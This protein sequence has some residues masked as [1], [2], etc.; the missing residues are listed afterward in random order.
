M[1]K[2]S[3]SGFKKQMKTT[4]KDTK[5][6]H[7]KGCMSTSNARAFLFQKTFQLKPQL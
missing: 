7:G 2:E 5:A 3:R 1:T 6:H 4:R